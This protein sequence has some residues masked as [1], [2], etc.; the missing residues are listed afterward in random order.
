[1]QSSAFNEEQPSEF[2]LF[3]DVEKVRSQ[4]APGTAVMVAIGGWGDTDGFEKAA[5]SEEGRKRF[6]R[7]VKKMVDETGADGMYN[8]EN[9]NRFNDCS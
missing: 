2:P 6:A 1:M 4:F 3:A 8:F 7:N 5:R 9:L